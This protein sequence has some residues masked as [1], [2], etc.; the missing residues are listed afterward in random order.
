MHVL[1]FLT[2]TSAIKVMNRVRALSISLLL[3]LFSHSLARLT[4]I[5]LSFIPFEHLSQAAIHT[6]HWF[7][8]GFTQGKLVASRCISSPSLSAPAIVT[9]NLV[10]DTK[11]QTVSHIFT[12]T[13]K[14]K[15]NEF[16][17]H[18]LQTNQ[19][20]HCLDLNVA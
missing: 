13:L 12:M 9:W 15:T 1:K 2:K 17:G 14:T 11:T 16:Y 4:P 10:S 18:P 19:K 20:N 3:H 7:A 8:V 5:P 6:I